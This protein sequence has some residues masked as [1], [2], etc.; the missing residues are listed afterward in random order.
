MDQFYTI[1]EVAD[2]CL[3]DIIEHLNFDEY[4]II[5]EPSA[6]TGSFYNKLPEDKR[7]GID[8]EPKCEG[9]VQLDFFKFEADVTKKYCVVGNPPFGR[10]SSTAV[11]FF[12]HAAEFADAIAFVIPKTF[13]RVSVQNRLNLNFHLIYNKDLPLKPCCFNPVMSA[14]CCLQIWKRREEKRDKILLPIVHED[15]E[16]IAWGELDTNGQPT[17]PDGADF[18][19]K[20]VGGNCGEVKTTGLSE[21]RPKSWHWIKSNI[22]TDELIRRMKSLNYEIS[23]DT[24]RQDSIGRAEIIQLYS[25]NFN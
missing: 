13:K 6:G 20:A 19:M 3:V 15:F 18:V 7:Q 12:N 2:E 24:V 21:L 1:P 11:K 16:F 10:V 14:K 23:R 9:V 8:L 4:D 17:P 25:Q 22:D 5:L